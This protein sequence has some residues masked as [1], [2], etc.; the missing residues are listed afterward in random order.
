MGAHL[1][2]PG[3]GKGL[4]KPQENRLLMPVWAPFWR[5]VAKKGRACFNRSLQPPWINPSL[6]W[7]S[8]SSTS[9]EVRVGH[10]GLVLGLPGLPAPRPPGTARGDLCLWTCQSTSGLASQQR[11]ELWLSVA[12]PLMHVSPGCTDANKTARQNHIPPSWLLEGFSFLFSQ[13]SSP[14]NRRFSSLAV[15]CSTPFTRQCSSNVH[16]K[17]QLQSKAQLT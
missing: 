7:P 9:W 4:A 1:E 3:A 17:L 6:P 11:A 5:W 12:F 14:R 13:T 8:S 10:G 16:E 2:I 15:P